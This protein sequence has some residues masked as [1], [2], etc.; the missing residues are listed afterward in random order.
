MRLVQEGI[1]GLIAG[2]HGKVS[3]L[4]ARRGLAYMVGYCKIGMILFAWSMALQGDGI[5]LCS[6]RRLITME[7]CHE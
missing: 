2:R 4:T 7:N 6:V 5:D 3:V 1:P